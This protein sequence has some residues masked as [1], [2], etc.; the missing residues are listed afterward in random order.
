MNEIIQ[1]VSDVIEN[2][3]ES[4]L[5]TTAAVQ[6]EIG[7]CPWCGSPIREGKKAFYCTN[8]EDCDFFIYKHD[9]RI[10]R[11]Y[12]A[13]EIGE[14][15]ESGRVTLRNCTSSK[16]NKYAAVFELDDSGEYVNLKFVEFVKTK[17]T[18]H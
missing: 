12:K 7:K 13:A 10:G 16:G 14:L 5:E 6:A 2:D 18:A 15:L 4:S 9:K 1:S 8:G 3:T 11:D 17:K